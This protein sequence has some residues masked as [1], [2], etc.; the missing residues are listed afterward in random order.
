MDKNKG[1]KEG[2][3]PLSSWGGAL[4]HPAW[5]SGGGEGEKKRFGGTKKKEE[6]K[7]KGQVPAYYP[8]KGGGEGES[9]GDKNIT[10]ERSGSQIPG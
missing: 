8:V 9:N 2:K 3:E 7:G 5:V 10:T 6:G 1:K 4:A